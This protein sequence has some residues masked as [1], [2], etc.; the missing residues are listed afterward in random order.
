MLFSILFNFKIC[1]MKNEKYYPYI[2]FIITAILLCL[3]NLNIV[4]SILWVLWLVAV[5][6]YIITDIICNRWEKKLEKR[7]KEIKKNYITKNNKNEKKE[8]IHDN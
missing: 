4:T 3:F 5:F 1:K 7:E 8:K 2:F 6:I